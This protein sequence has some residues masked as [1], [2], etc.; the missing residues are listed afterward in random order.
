MLSKTVGIANSLLCQKKK[1]KSRILSHKLR[2]VSEVIVAQ[3]SGFAHH[4]DLWGLIS[5]P[6][7]IHSNTLH[8]ENGQRLSYP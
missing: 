7:I 3:A 1:G 5:V 8:D 4:V 2:T 6:F